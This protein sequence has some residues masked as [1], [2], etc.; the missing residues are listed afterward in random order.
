MSS[1]IDRG[2]LSNRGSARRSVGQPDLASL[3]G[4][5]H[6]RTA[7]PD[8]LVLGLQG[9][10]H[11]LCTA[12]DCFDIRPSPVGSWPEHPVAVARGCEGAYDPTTV[13]DTVNGSGIQ[14][15]FK[16]NRLHRRSNGQQ[17][18]VPPRNELVGR[19]LSW[20]FGEP[21]LCRVIERLE[22]PLNA[23]DRHSVLF[24]SCGPC[25]LDLHPSDEEGTS[26]RSN[27]T[28]GLHPSGPLG[29]GHAERPE[30]DEEQ[31]VLRHVFGQLDLLL[32]LPQSDGLI[33]RMCAVEQD[34]PVPAPRAQEVAPIFVDLGRH[35]IEHDA[36]RTPPACPHGRI[37]LQAVI[38]ADHVQAPAG[39]ARHARLR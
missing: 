32:G 12:G 31:A 11:H 7:S 4:C 10:F 16:L 24:P 6:S 38:V 29:L 5:A 1:K 19:R 33:S 18:R 25:M 3:F 14:Q 35:G 21:R 8:S 23:S 17:L 22:Q 39:Q 26:D 36:E 34:V 13:H 27:S 30:I 20:L 15:E 2:S 9:E 28:D 37:L